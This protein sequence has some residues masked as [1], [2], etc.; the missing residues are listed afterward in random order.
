MGGGELAA[1][2]EDASRDEGK[3]DVALSRGFGIDKT[4]ELQLAEAAERSGYMTVGEPSN[5][6]EAFLERLDEVMYD[7][8]ASE[9][10]ADLVAYGFGEL[11]DVGEGEFAL[12]SLDP[13]GLTY[14]PGGVGTAVGNALDIHRQI[15]FMIQ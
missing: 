12:L 15:W 8:A 13:F 2:V 7:E 5:K 4:L 1:G 3:H 10:F 6:G 14:E 11:G 9:Q